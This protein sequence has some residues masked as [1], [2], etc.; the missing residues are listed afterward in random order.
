MRVKGAH[1]VE[2]VFGRRTLKQ[3]MLLM[4]NTTLDLTFPAVGGREV[5]SRNDGG[6]IT[7]DA[8]LLLISLADKKLG[9]TRGMADAIDD[10]RNRS[11][12]VHPVIEMARERIYAICQDYED[13]NDLDTLRHDPA[14]KVACGRL[15]KTGEVLASQPTISRFE[16][17]PGARE[18]ARM[19]ESMAERVISQLPMDTRRIIIDV[20]PTE[21]AVHGQQEFEFFNGHYGC[22]CY[23]PVHIHITGDDGRQR[24]I[25]SVLRPGNSGATKG[26]YSVLRIAIRLVRKSMP[27]ARI[28]LRADSA[29]GV[30]A[31]LDFCE[32]MGVDYILGMKA[33]KNLHLLSTPVQ[34][35]AC[36]KYKW[37]GN[38]CREYGEFIYGA[39]TWRHPRRIVVKA[40]IT[41][42]DLNPRFVVTSLLEL[43]DVEAYLFYCGRG[44]QENR[45]KEIKLDLSSGRTS[46]HSFLANQF[47]LLMHTA[48]CMLMGVLQESLAGTRFAKAQIGTLRTRILKVGAR[49]VETA[50]KIWFHLPTSFPQKEMWRRMYGALVPD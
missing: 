22:H 31:V 43:S 48:A 9:L 24:I 32:D 18:M 33:N 26:L 13:A 15:P 47:R 29:F 35:D 39:R 11:K 16:N 28:I 7:S 36:L 46:C 19:A 27:D 34:M 50:R 20:D 14:L 45:I 8:G 10:H 38:G 1:S 5:V 3:R 23:L 41:Q 40:E 37:E 12:V 6:D 30:C 49:V 17:M 42:G 25:G 44:E 21:D 4:D 2:V